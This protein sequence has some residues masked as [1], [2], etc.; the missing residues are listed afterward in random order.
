M[1]K[2]LL[3]PLLKVLFKQEIRQL[4]WAAILQFLF[5]FLW[6]EESALRK[7]TAI[8]C[9]GMIGVAKRNVCR[10]HATLLQYQSF[11]TCESSLRT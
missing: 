10:S 5:L 4:F 7:A 8:V 2:N 6:V 9:K 1:E 3:R 11:W